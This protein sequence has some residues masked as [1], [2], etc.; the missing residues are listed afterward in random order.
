[1]TLHLNIIDET[2]NSTVSELLRENGELI[3][4][5][6]EDGDREVKEPG[7]TR[8]PGGTYPVIKRTVGGFYNRYS[9]RF[10]HDFVPW[11]EPVPGFTWILFHIGNK[12]GDTRGCLLTNTYYWKA[13]DGNYWGKNSSSAY[14]KLYAELKAAFDRG[15]E[16]SL[17]VNRDY[18]SPPENEEEDHPVEPDEDSG[19]GVETD[20]PEPL[21]CAAKIAIALGWVF[22][23]KRVTRFNNAA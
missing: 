10:G 4:Y 11:I 6:I 20:K 8:I 22:D 17:V 14:L 16:V 7:V 15:E 1:M 18:P 12:V 9:Q 19:S 21:G 3:C 23:S 5:V 13:V 2:R